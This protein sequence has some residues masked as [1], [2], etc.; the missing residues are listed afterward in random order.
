[1]R[2]EQGES[3][4]VRMMETKVALRAFRKFALAMV[5]MATDIARHGAS[6]LRWMILKKPSNA[7]SAA[8]WNKPAWPGPAIV[9]RCKESCGLAPK[10]AEMIHALVALGKN[11]KSAVE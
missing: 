6:P 11:I 5:P 9:N 4:P 8:N 2:A 7:A 10:S 1:M 3:V